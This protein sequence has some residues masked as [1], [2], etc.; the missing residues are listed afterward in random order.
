MEEKGQNWRKRARCWI[1]FLGEELGVRSKPGKIS[2]K[3]LNSPGKES[4][5]FLT[6]GSSL[7]PCFLCVSFEKKKK[8]QLFCSK[9]GNRNTA[10]IYHCSVSSPAL[11]PIKSCSSAFEIR[12]YTLKQLPC[13]ILLFDWHYILDQDKMERQISVFVHSISVLFIFGNIARK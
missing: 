11:I 1:S 2:M 13:I 4:S 9:L 3:N 7:K 5:W 8:R 12:G 6:R 10:V